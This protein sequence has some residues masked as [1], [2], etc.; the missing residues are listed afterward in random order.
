MKRSMRLNMLEGTEPSAH[1]RDYTGHIISRKSCDLRASY[2]AFVVLKND[3]LDSGSRKKLRLRIIAI[4]RFFAISRLR[5][6][7]RREPARS[8]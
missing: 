1:D 5:V 4:N 6:R 3:V 8:I 7:L 2:P